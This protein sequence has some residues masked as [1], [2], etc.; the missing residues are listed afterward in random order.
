MIGNQISEICAYSSI[1][2]AVL[3]PPNAALS[4][5]LSS[6][7]GILAFNIALLEVEYGKLDTRKGKFKSAEALP[8]LHGLCIFAQD[9]DGLLYYISGASDYY[10]TR[11]PNKKTKIIGNINFL[12]DF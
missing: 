4:C 1:P 7:S 10:T 8:G 3:S 9:N 6:L 12:L 11:E 5:L 2:I